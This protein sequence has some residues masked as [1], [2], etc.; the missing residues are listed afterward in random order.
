[1]PKNHRVFIWQFIEGSGDAEFC[2][3]VQQHLHAAL[4]DK[5]TLSKRQP[6]KE[7]ERI[8]A[9]DRQLKWDDVRAA[10]KGASLPF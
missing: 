1:M 10:M 5:V 8:V 6:R 2:T 7:G 3:W 4:P 9:L